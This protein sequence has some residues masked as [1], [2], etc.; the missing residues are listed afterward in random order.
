[1]A[2]A[3][4][5]LQAFRLLID[6]Q[7]PG[8]RNMAVDEA[9]LRC[10]APDGAAVLRLYGFAPA[11]V[12]LGRFQTVGDL[13]DDVARIRDGVD[14]V[15]RP[16][17][18]RA[19]LHDDEVTYA[20]VLGRHHVQPF[21]KRAAYRT[22]AALLLRLLGALGVR[23]AVHPGDR[24]APAADADPDCY[25][26]TGEYEITAGAK[27]LVGSAQITTRD[28]ALQHG[29]IPL[30]TSYS[31]IARYLRERGSA[32]EEGAIPGATSVAV[33]SGRRWRYHEALHTLAA[34]AR[35]HLGAEPSTLSE[36]EVRLARDLETT[37]YGR[38]QWTCAR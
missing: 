12:S 8:A 32:R 1:M 28:A 3:V 16:T 2:S 20:V 25:H 4:P 9:L 34:A 18:G 6:P 26:A 15:R 19:V 36:A 5:S 17:G 31:R 23:G 24:T 29:S 11:C 13:A 21:T 22:S 33:E 37:R 35:A 14:V 10:M 7:L 30:S 38:S 27:K